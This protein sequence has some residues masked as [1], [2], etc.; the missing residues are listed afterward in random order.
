MKIVLLEHPD[1]FHE[2]YVEPQMKTQTLKDRVFEEIQHVVDIE[3]AKTI[4]LFLRGQPFGADASA[5]TT[6][7][8]VL[9][10]KFNVGLD[11]ARVARGE[12]LELDVK[13]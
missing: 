3:D 2:F 10:T 7:G 4:R 12:P 5:D 8:S 1:E 9:T 13:Y 11:S 6:V